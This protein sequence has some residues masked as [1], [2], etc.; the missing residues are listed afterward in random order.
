MLIFPNQFFLLLKGLIEG[1]LAPTYVDQLRIK[2]LYLLLKQLLLFPFL[3]ELVRS[4]LQGSHHIILIFL[5][6]LLL[7][8]QLDEL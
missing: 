6:P 1:V 5:D 8:L 3:V 4:L 7:L 2:G